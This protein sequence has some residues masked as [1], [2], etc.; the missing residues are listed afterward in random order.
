MIFD[1]QLFQLGSDLEKVRLSDSVI[2][3]QYGTN[4]FASKTGMTGFGAPRDVRGSHLHSL[5]ED[6]NALRV[7]VLLN[8]R[9]DPLRLIYTAFILF[10]GSD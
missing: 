8:H 7:R 1:F 9:I 2:G 3:P 10:F 5:T 6:L 4:Q